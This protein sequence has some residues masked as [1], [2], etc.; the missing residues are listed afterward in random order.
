MY[1]TGNSGTTLA[2]LSLQRQDF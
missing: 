2:V 1:S